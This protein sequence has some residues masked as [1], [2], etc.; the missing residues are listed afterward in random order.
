M[1]LAERSLL[2]WPGKMPLLGWDSQRTGKLQGCHAVMVTTLIVQ[3]VSSTEHLAQCSG[4]IWHLTWYPLASAGK[5]RLFPKGSTLKERFRG[6]YFLNPTKESSLQSL[7]PTIPAPPLP[8]P[9]RA[10][11]NFSH[12]PCLSA[13]ATFPTTYT[14]K[15]HR[16]L[17]SCLMWT[18]PCCLHYLWVM[19]MHS[20]HLAP[21]FFLWKRKRQKLC[22][23]KVEVSR[24]C[25]NYSTKVWR[26]ASDMESIKI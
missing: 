19:S 14:I 3:V 24:W 9:I 12:S 8:L 13:L 22:G 11:I 15:K 23:L 20:S 17:S 25:Y 10:G 5:R 21:T 18:F 2:T 16:L 1:G 26:N 6:P 7:S 4:K